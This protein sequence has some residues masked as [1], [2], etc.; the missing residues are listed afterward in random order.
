MIPDGIEP[1][2]EWLADEFD[3]RSAA[4]ESEYAVD[5]EDHIA[6]KREREEFR[7]ALLTLV[8][9]A[10]VCEDPC[11][12]TGSTAMEQGNRG[13]WRQAEGALRGIGSSE[14]A[15]VVIRRIRGDQP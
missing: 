15:E 8:E 6:A 14:P 2:V 10:K 4:A 5:R 11:C 7:A 13:N 1:L 3:L 12:P 9:R